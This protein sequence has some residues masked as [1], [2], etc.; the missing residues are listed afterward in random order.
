MISNNDLVHRSDLF[1]MGGVDAHHR[2]LMR[3][4][5]IP[6]LATK[7]LP[8]TIVRSVDGSDA[9]SAFLEYWLKSAMSEGP[10]DLMTAVDA[11]RILG[12]SVDMVRLLARNGRLPFM[13]TVR[14]V[15]LFRRAD[16][17]S[18]AQARASG[19]RGRATST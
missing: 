9:R 19:K 7:V 6:R 14:G 3:S 10:D 11:G 8:R 17:E 16:V 2:K 5:R 15:R 18:L 4:R 1:R 13:S 12:V